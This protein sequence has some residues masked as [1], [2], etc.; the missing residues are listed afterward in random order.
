[1]W[2]TSQNCCS[3]QQYCSL[4]PTH[5]LVLNL[6]GR[7]AENRAPS[8]TSLMVFSSR[9]PPRH[10]FWQKGILCEIACKMDLSKKHTACLMISAT[11]SQIPAMRHELPENFLTFFLYFCVYLCFEMNFKNTPYRHLGS[12]QTLLPKFRNLLFYR[13]FVL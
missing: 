2:L 5:S 13:W 10:C 3:A 6:W 1:M 8:N 9:W 12:W 7:N 4:L 11:K